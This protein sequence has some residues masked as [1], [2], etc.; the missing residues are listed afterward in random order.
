MDFKRFCEL[1]DQFEE[2]EV[3]H[4]QG[5]G[6]P[7]MHPRFFEMVGYAVRKKIKVTTNSNLTIFNED[8][9]KL[10]LS[11]GLSVLNVSV[12]G[13]EQSTYEKIRA[14]GKFRTV[15]ENLNLLATVKRSE[16]S[17]RPEVR[18]VMVLMKQNLQELP[19]LIGLAKKWGASSVSAQHLCHDFGESSL[20]N[21]Y[22]PMRDYIDE[23]TLENYDETLVDRYFGEARRVA[24][25]LHVS[26][27]LPRLKPRPHPPCTPGPSRCDW[28]WSRMYI[29][30]DGRSMPCC[31]VGTP[32]RVNFGNMAETG[33][34]AVWTNEAYESFRH[35][36][37]SENPPEV[38][39][40]CSLYKGTF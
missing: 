19:A 20:P 9:A 14:G 34:K 25:D 32:D 33:V 35:R 16:K 23:Q 1:V 29:S 10:C 22:K 5:L 39:R 6:E 15:A 26:L 2:A 8:R 11:S 31:M 12:D 36:L 27:R 37:D 7:M 40:S 38:C 18:I 17:E 21:V 4:L 3:L 28:P 24:S 13:A 30:Y